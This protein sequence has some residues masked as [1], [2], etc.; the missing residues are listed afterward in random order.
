MKNDN[1]KK[2]LMNILEVIENYLWAVS[3]VQCTL[4]AS[5]RMAGV[6][7][8]EGQGTFM[9]SLYGL[10]AQPCNNEIL[11]LRGSNVPSAHGRTAIS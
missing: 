6:D 11:A 5:G 8:G 1:L 4:F 3:K 2:L 10:D 9:L 7:A